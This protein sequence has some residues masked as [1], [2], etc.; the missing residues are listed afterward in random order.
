MA[1]NYNQNIYVYI[2]DLKI[3][4]VVTGNNNFA[5]ILYISVCLKYTL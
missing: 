4:D 3:S 2:S 5:R 1:H